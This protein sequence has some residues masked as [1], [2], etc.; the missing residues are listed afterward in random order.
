MMV[1]N[2]NRRAAAIPGGF[3]AGVGAAVVMMLVMALL[4]F[5]SNTITIPELMEES[6]IRLTGGRIES[7]FINNL[8]VGCKAL[9]L[10]T[11][12]VGT[13][14]LG[15]VLGFA[16]TRSWPALGGIAGR[17]WLSGLLYGLVVGL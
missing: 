11:I 1:T 9:L 16:F 5:I 10:V 14:L 13:L 7:F 3:G 17:R 15:A 8:G 4:R 6:L 2:T 12:V